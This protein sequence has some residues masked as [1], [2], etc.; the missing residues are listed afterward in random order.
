MWDLAPMTIFINYLLYVGFFSS[1]QYRTD[2]LY[3]IFYT[4]KES[5]YA[6]ENEPN[7]PIS[8][9]TIIHQYATHVSFSIKK[10][11]LLKHH[12]L[13]KRHSKRNIMAF[14]KHTHLASHVTNFMSYKDQSLD[15][16][17][18]YLNCIQNQLQKQG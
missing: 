14:L 6:Q 2:V 4:C 16:Q 9:S 8:I 12:S 15:L 10:L 18:T 13:H 1:S 11:H 3:T 17:F 7:K 5:L